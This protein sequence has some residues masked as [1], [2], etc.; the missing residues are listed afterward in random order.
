VAVAHGEGRADFS[1]TGDAEQV[2]VAVRFVDGRGAVATTYPKNPN[3]SPAGITGVTSAD[4]RVT[5]MMPHPERIF[6]A[7]Q[8][9]WCPGDWDE[10]FAGRGPWLRMFEG[11]RQF[12]G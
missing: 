12:V 4:G 3:G 8:H 10:K 11:A 5:L 6:R 7:V 1:Q 9:S 2:N